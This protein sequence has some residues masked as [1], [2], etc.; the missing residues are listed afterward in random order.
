MQ[1]HTEM[2]CMVVPQTLVYLCQVVRDAWYWSPVH[3]SCY[4]KVDASTQHHR[5]KT[6][7]HPD[8]Q[9]L[10]DCQLACWWVRHAV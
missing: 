9:K 8:I 1:K 6:V 3:G 2:P 4:G 7:H 5:A 10:L